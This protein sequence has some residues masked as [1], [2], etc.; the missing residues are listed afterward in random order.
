M[1]ASLFHGTIVTSN[2]IIYTPSAFAKSNLIYLQ[3]TGQLQAKKPHVSQR[4]NLSSYLF[5]IVKSGSGTLT[6]EGETFALAAGDCIFLD[7][8]KPYSHATSDALWSL[9]WVHFYGQSLKNIYK[10]YLKNGGQP[11][12]HTTRLSA[13]EALL[14]DLF[15]AASSDGAVKELKICEKLTSLL[16]LLL[17]EC[18]QPQADTANS[19]GKRD[20]Q[21]V[22]NYL[23]DHFSE[24]ITLEMLERMF[25]INKFY[26]ARLFKEQFGSSVNHYLLQV[27]ITQ[28]KHLLRFTSLSIEEV[29]R[30]CGMS[31][32][33]YFAR[34]FKKVEGITPRGYRKLW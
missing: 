12:F 27:R 5:F 25:F 4:E 28:A 2:R 19:A 22:K 9:K 30:R 7:C 11:C 3:E 6:Y 18:T 34:M 17:E 24:K 29:A 16:V 13:Y 1:K 20:L 23:D 14:D 15:L 10:K 8:Q 26:L 33:N 21:E 31:D 32:A